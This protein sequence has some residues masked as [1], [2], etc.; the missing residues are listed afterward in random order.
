M[1]SCAHTPANPISALS[2][3]LCTWC[4]FSIHAASRAQGELGAARDSLPLLVPG[5]RSVYHTGYHAENSFG[6][7][8]YLILRP[9]GSSGGSGA[10]NILVDVPRW[11]PVLAQRI[12]QLGGVHYIFL[13][14]EDDV[15]DHAKW[16]E[17]FG[18]ERII[19]RKAASRRQG[20]T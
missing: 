6:A 1:S 3:P 12:K 8:P 9:G 10:E 11:S 15:G 13:T 20:T 5:C 16:A 17:H 7:T 18:A 2:R 14:H 19:H 4:R